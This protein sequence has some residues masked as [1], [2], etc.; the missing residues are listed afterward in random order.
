M[1]EENNYP[2]AEP[3]GYLPSEE[4][5]TNSTVNADGR[6]DVDV[7][8]KLARAL[9]VLYAPPDKSEIQ[10]APPQYLQSVTTDGPESFPVK[11]N[12]VIQVVGSRG[13]VQPF[14]ALGH[15]L[16]KYGH[17]VRVAT[18]NVFDDFVRK[19]GSGLEFYPIGGNPS[20]LMAYMVKNPGLIPSMKTIQAGEIKRKRLMTGSPGKAFLESGPPPVYIGFGSIVLEDPQRIT[21]A[22]MEAVERNGFR[23]IVSKGWSNLGSNGESHKDVLFIGDCPHEW[24]FQRVAAVIHHGG[25]GTTACGLKNGRPTTIVPFFGDQPFWGDMCAVAGAG[26]APIPQ[27][28]LTTDTLSAA[29]RYCL[30]DEAAVAAVAIAQKMQ[31]ETGVQNA[32]R[33]FHQH[34]PIDRV[35]C[36]IMP[37]LPAAFR[38]KKGK[39]DIK[40][41][42]LAAELVFQKFPK[43]AKHLE[44][45]QSKPFMIEPRRWD[46]ISGGA[47]SVMSTAVDLGTSVTGIFTKPYTDYRN[48]RDWRAYQDCIRDISS[49]SNSLGLPAKDSDNSSIHSA[50]SATKRKPVSAGQMAGA[51]GKSIA[52]FAPKATKGMLVDIPMA[53][54]DG[55]KNVPRAYGDKVRE[56]GP[57]TGFTSGA[58]VAGKTFAYGFYDGLSGIVV[59]PYQGA[60]KEGAIGA[61]KGV[62]KGLVGLSTKTGAGMFGLVGYT[63]AGIAKSLRT[64]VYSGTRKSIAAARHAE[65]QWMIEQGRY[66]AQEE[67][68]ITSRFETL[69]RK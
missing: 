47:A 1:Q 57:V 31:T 42:S 63:G 6:I 39:A 5:A 58:T 35:A 51:S 3:P 23:A 16:R 33:S 53:L 12:I 24:L 49:A 54:T 68:S 66:G 43:D 52:M 69:K 32:V 48:D 20:E 4:L 25:A 44:L 8:S 9:S 50:T 7:N 34:L 15:E 14:I 40:L 62:A 22:I 2:I 59:K 61:A 17:R 18:H 46:P 19:S 29:I 10:D 41:S 45:Y 55:L 27:K 67:A 60:Q 65:G 56:H 21:A 11:L 36:D 30:S 13:D 26:P 38:F 64:A 37:H 28:Q